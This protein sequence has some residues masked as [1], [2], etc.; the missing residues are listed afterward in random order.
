MVLR[1]Q[2]IGFLQAV[3]GELHGLDDLPVASATADIARDRLDDFL[4]ARR[5]GMLKQ[6]VRGQDHARRAV[7]ALQTV[8][9]AERI[10]NDAE[11]ARAGARPSI[12]VIS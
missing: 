11:F 5:V 12:V 2:R 3:C 1:P 4:A 10:L 8:G 9:F 7:A 6:R